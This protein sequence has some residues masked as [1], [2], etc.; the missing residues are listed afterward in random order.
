MKV[1]VTGGIKSGKSRFAE[2]RCLELAQGNIP[3]YLATSALDD[4]EMHKR[5]AR[6][7]ERRKNQFI[8]IEEPL[9]LFRVISGCQ[10]TVLVECLTLWLNNMLYQE[11]PEHT[12]FEEI[13]KV[14]QLSHNLVLVN[15]EVGLGVIPNNALARQFVDLSGKLSQMV[16]H[17]ADEIYFCVA[18]QA[19]RMK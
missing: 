2:K 15:N 5:I 8:T 9:A 14:M 4:P 13:E 19:L 17:Y 18:G 3:I 7:Q 10:A 16:G 1:L 11:K 6:H 12:I